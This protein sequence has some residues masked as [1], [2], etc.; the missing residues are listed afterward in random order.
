MAV[1]PSVHHTDRIDPCSGTLED[2]QNA[3]GGTGHTSLQPLA[4]RDQLLGGW[5]Y[6]RHQISQVSAVVVR[7]PGA[8]QLVS[9][10]IAGKR[11]FGFTLQQPFCFF[12]LFLLSGL[13]HVFAFKKGCT[14]CA[15]CQPAPR[16][17]LESPG[18]LLA[19]LFHGQVD[20]ERAH[21]LRG[22]TARATRYDR[23]G[24]EDPG[25]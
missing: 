10:D 16:Q 8:K 3:E 12:S 21:V 23:W 2:M 11:A 15:Y 7:S 5:F 20:G 25:R 17:N 9:V 13:L 18:W 14:Y 22:L 1:P 19:S 24:L 6:S 4:H